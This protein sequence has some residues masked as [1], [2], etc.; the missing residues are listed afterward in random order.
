MSKLYSFIRHDIIKGQ[1]YRTLLHFLVSHDLLRLS[2]CCKSLVDYRHHMSRITVA[3]HPSMVS[4][5][6]KRALFDLLLGQRE[7]FT[8]ILSHPEIG[9][10]M[11][12]CG[13]LC[14]KNVKRIE[15]RGSC[16]LDT[17]LAC[18]TNP[19]THQ[20]QYTGGKGLIMTQ[21]NGSLMNSYGGQTSR[22]QLK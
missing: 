11:D 15:C 16:N 4:L 20:W 12:K 14:C 1:G 8:L 17:S 10:V 19:L 9:D 5:R 13:W 21:N 18:G 6:I 7:D 22:R 2:E 3:P